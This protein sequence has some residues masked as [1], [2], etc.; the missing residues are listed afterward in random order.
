MSTSHLKLVPKPVPQAKPQ[1]VPGPLLYTGQG[2]CLDAE[3]AAALTDLEGMVGDYLV[4]AEEGIAVAL[5]EP[6][7]AGTRC[8]FWDES[9]AV[10]RFDGRV[11]MGNM[12]IALNGHAVKS[13]HLQMQATQLQGPELITEGE[14]T[15]LCLTPSF[16]CHF[17]TDQQAASL[18]VIH[19]LESQRI[20]LL[21]D[22]RQYYLLETGDKPVLYLETE[23]DE[24]VKPI[25]TRQESGMKQAYHYQCT[26]SQAIPDE[27][28]GQAVISVTVLERYS[29][30]FMQ[31]PLL[32]EETS[33]WVPVYAPISWGWSM[34][35]GRRYDGVWAM[36]RRKLVLP[37]TGHDGLQL[38]VWRSNSLA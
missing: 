24:A 2:Y 18:G 38:P 29:S 15:S 19:L 1:P 7:E 22:G 4:G 26:V 34:R 35:I 12:A 33:I 27:I 37:T 32:A 13:N 16:D 21:D 17:V 23:D 10:G 14:E 9:V 31:R 36:Q 5:G 28:D 25:I 3:A 6:G 30:Y 11:V 8:Y 20:A